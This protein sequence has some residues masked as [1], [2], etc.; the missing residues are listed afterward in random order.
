MKKVYTPLSIFLS[1]AVMLSCFSS[2]VYASSNSY[3]E[4]WAYWW[5]EYVCGVDYNNYQNTDE[6]STLDEIITRYGTNT[7]NNTIDFYGDTVSNALGSDSVSDMIKNQ[8]ATNGEFAKNTFDNIVTTN[9]SVANYVAERTARTFKDGDREFLN[10]SGD[11]FFNSI[12]ND[13]FN[14]NGYKQQYETSVNDV[15]TGQYNGNNYNFRLIKDKNV[16]YGDISTN[17]FTNLKTSL[18]DGGFQYNYYSFYLIVNVNGI[19]Y[20]SYNFTGSETQFGNTYISSIDVIDNVVYVHCPASFGSGQTISLIFSNGAPSENPNNEGSQI[21]KPKSCGVIRYNGDW[22]DVPIDE[23][24]RPE[25]MII[26]P[27]G[28]VT[29]PDGNDY[30]IYVEVPSDDDEGEITPEGYVQIIKVIGDDPSGNHIGS[31]YDQYNGDDGSGDNSN[32]PFGLGIGDFFSNIAKAVGNGLSSLLG[33]IID[34]IKK[35]LNILLELFKGS[36][37]NNIK[38]PKFEIAFDFNIIEEILKTFFGALG[39]TV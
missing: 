25:G 28:T 10:V 15:W 35:L 6:G 33:G 1:L 36:W 13:L 17:V 2:A 26:N 5:G 32:N 19:E 20:Y 23:S 38:S 30:P 34:L 18:Q 16:P 11:S 12:Y 29:M 37:I 24:D 7:V 39:A 4:W 22:L 21:P 3:P 8:I 14:N 31:P 9:Q 27:N